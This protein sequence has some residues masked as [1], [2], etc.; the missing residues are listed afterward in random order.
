M[1]RVT[2]AGSIWLVYVAIAP[3]LIT[4]ML[5]V[6]SNV[7]SFFGGTGLLIV[8]G[9][10]LD[11]S[12]RMEQYLLMQHYQGFLEGGGRVIGRR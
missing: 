2:L 6:S 10:A 1:R 7:G 9:V 4:W 8:V 5:K 3:Q 11:L 12:Q